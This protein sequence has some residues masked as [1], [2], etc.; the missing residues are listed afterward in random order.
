MYQL[1]IAQFIR[2]SMCKSSQLH[3]FELDP[4]FAS[5]FSPSHNLVRL[6]LRLME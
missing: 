4:F 6:P 5:R 3:A 1:D 2:D